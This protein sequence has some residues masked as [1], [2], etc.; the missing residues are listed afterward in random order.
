MYGVLIHLKSGSRERIDP[1]VSIN[2]YGEDEISI[3]NSYANY[4]HKIS[5]IKSIEFYKVKKNRKEV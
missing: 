2:M 3:D 5:D 4:Y 1:L